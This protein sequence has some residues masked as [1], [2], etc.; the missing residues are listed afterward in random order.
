MCCAIFLADGMGTSLTTSTRFCEIQIWL[1]VLLIGNFMVCLTYG[2]YERVL[3]LLTMLSGY[4]AL[5]NCGFEINE[6]SEM[7]TLD[8]Y[9]N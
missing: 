1:P 2:Q 7:M 3:C 6:A 9:K 5:T 8:V 4:I